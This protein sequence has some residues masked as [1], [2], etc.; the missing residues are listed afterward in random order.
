MKPQIANYNLHQLRFARPSND[1]VV[2]WPA[3]KIREDGDDVDLHKALNS[4]P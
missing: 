2:H 1:S 4:K 3:K